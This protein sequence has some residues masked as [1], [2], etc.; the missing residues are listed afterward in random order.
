[1]NAIERDKLII[2]MHGD[3]QAVK[4]AIEGNGAPGLH[5]RLM[6]VE[7][8]IRSRPQHCPHVEKKGKVLIRL[9]L[10]V[11]VVVA[12]FKGIDLLGKALG[13]W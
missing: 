7:N 11:S 10:E 4:Q 2:E 13:R 8:W 5:D 12:I 9:G 3:M 6:F 1:M